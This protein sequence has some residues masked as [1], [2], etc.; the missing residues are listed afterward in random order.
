MERIDKQIEKLELTWER[1]TIS[2]HPNAIRIYKGAKQVF[3]GTEDAARDFLVEYESSR[4]K[5]FNESMIGYK[6]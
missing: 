2:G 4:P 3:I 6:E 5:P 1:T